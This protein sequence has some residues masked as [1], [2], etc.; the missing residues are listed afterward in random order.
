ML[1]APAQSVLFF[2]IY[3]EAAFPLYA[4]LVDDL[5]NSP[6]L[7]FQLA[8]TLEDIGQGFMKLAEQINGELM[9][10]GVLDQE[11]DADQTIEALI[12]ALMAGLTSSGL[13]KWAPPDGSPLL[14]LTD[15][16]LQR[17]LRAALLMIHDLP[18]A[19]GIAN[20]HQNT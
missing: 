17:A 16:T 13:A 11:V 8:T 4:A 3:R 7:P 2:R 14:A 10:R 1:T 18:I 9:Q 12:D 20:Q 15:E 19:A 5:C 6:H